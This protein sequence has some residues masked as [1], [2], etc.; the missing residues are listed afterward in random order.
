MSWFHEIIDFHIFYQRLNIL[1][2]HTKVHGVRLYQHRGKELS[3]PALEWFHYTVYQG[4]LNIVQRK[5]GHGH[6]NIFI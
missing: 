3:W 1:Q 5:S 2:H 6:K 4:E